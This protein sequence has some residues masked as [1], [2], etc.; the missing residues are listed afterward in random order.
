MTDSKHYI[1]VLIDPNT[2]LPRYVG[3][4]SKSA[5]ARAREHIRLAHHDNGPSR[6]H[7]WIR[8]ISPKS[9]AIMIAQVIVGDSKDAARAEIKWQKRLERFDLLQWVDRTSHNYRTLVNT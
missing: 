5:N 3:R 4:T 7:R 6:L 2:G 1:Y 9:P 8:D